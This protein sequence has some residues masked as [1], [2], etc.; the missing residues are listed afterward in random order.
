MISPDGYKNIFI[1]IVI[2]FLF[3]ILIYFFPIIIFKI[4]TA[5]IGILV[6]FNIYF[7]RDPERE[8]PQG[9]NLLVSPADGKIVKIDEVYEPFYF[10]S[11][12]TCISIFLSIFDVHV[13]R[14]PMSGKIDFLKYN[15]GKFLVAY[16]DKA[17][18]DNEQSIIG[19]RKGER[20]ILFKQIAGIIA[21]RIIYHLSMNDSVRVGERFGLIRYGSRVDI[22]FSGNV[23]IKV[24]LNDH[25]YGGK[26]IIAEFK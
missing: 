7:H 14:I 5:L 3:L 26:T 18:Q 20:R 10:K 6:L 19:I 22:F 12:V 21:R 17:S 23:E 11:N 2:F 25:V 24:N 1:S 15:N 16:N 4:L 8:I 13:N 9:E